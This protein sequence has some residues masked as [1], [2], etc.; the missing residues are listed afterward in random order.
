MKIVIDTN[1]AI[2]GLLWG[3]APNQILRLCRNGV[4]RILECDETLDEVKRVI[5]YDKFTDRLSDLG[6]KGIEVFAY[7]MN[8]V[9]Y[10]PS[11]KII[12]DLIKPD[13]FDNM[14]LGLAPENNASL[15]VSSDSHLLASVSYEG[16]QIVAPSEGV[17]VISSLLK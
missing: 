5:Q 13:P 10:V 4:I 1:V 3:G 17:Q 2:S 9:T 14:F 7:F 8:L 6:I 11:P 12:P 16:I 15:I